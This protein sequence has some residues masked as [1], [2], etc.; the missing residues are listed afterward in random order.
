MDRKEGVDSMT[1][2]PIAGLISE[3]EPDDLAQ[4]AEGDRGNIS[5]WLSDLRN[6][7]YT[8]EVLDTARIREG[9]ANWYR[10]EA[11]GG[12]DVGRLPEF[13]VGAFLGEADRAFVVHPSKLGISSADGRYVELLLSTFSRAAFIRRGEGY[14][15]PRLACSLSANADHESQFPTLY[16]TSTPDFRPSRATLKR[17]VVLYHLSNSQGDCLEIS[18]PSATL[19]AAY[20]E[21]LAANRAMLTMNG[22]GGFPEQL[23]SIKFYFHEV[24]S[25]ESAAARAKDISTTLFF[26]LSAMDR[27]SFRLHEALRP[28]DRGRIRPS[29]LFRDS[30]VRFPPQIVDHRAAS[31]FVNADD[32]GA[33]LSRYL[34]YYQTVEYFLPFSDEKE[35]IAR[36]RREIFSP[37]F[38]LDNNRS[39]L[40]LA[41]TIGQ[42][43][44]KSEQQ[45]FRDLVR[46]VLSDDKA[47]AIFESVSTDYPDHFGK[48]GGIKHVPFIH[49]SD[50]TRTLPTQLADRIYKLRCRIVHSKAAGGAIGIEPLFPTD[51][52]V[53][54]ISPDLELVRLVAVEAITNFAAA[55]SRR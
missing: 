42:Q 43:A 1:Q 54:L 51:D 33:P 14:A 12:K 40:D 38:D 44:S 45:S 6:R 17:P 52:E 53:N 47:V 36:I 7:G 10:L 49:P 29:R 3:D 9:A 50:T 16:G 34:L 26:E 5:G 55:S 46:L 4:S 28:R 20:R 35:S 48:R 11:P 41:R 23:N 27:A 30:A 32:A 13:A 8:I 15:S 37:G 18:A 31:L 25:P 21:A 39:L 2:E 22:P 19:F 24:S